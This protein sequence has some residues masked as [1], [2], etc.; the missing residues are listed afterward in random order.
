MRSTKFPAPA[1]EKE[2]EK[3]KE[4]Q[5]DADAFNKKRAHGE[6]RGRWSGLHWN[7]LSFKFSDSLPS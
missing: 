5:L 7:G 6:V 1:S 2:V 3:T 4:G